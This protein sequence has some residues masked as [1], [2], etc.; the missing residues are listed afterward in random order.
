M[1]AMSTLERFACCNPIWRIVTSRVVIPWV[2]AGQDVEGDVLEL[3][4]GSG[5]NAAAVLERYGGVSL[6]VTDVDPAMLDAARKHLAGFGA[7]ASVRSVDAARL[8][9]GQA[10][11]D[12][13]LSMIM[14]HHVGDRSAALAEARRV[15]R[16][17]G[18]LVGY[19]LCRSGPAAWL[20]RSGRSSHDYMTADGLRSELSDAG[21]VRIVV[22]PAPSGLAARF[23]ADAPDQ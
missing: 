7:R 6:T 15:L 8:P 10:T 13:V 19:D 14:L 11:F 20:H 18:R 2:L 23:S 16:P 3:G 9:F 21:L 22:Q 4:S 17:G 1:A 12:V 5:A